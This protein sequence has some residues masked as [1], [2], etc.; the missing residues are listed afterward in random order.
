MSGLCTLI[1]SCP[2]FTLSS[3]RV[4]MSTT[5]PLASE[6]TGTSRAISGFT[7]PV[8]FNRAGASIRLAATNENCSGFSTVTTPVLLVSVTFAGGAAPS[9]GLN[10]FSHAVKERQ[11]VRYPIVCKADLFFIGEPHALRQDS[12]GWR[13]SDRRQ[14]TG[15]RPV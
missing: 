3:R 6:I 10:F 7:D 5:R 15:D 12:F 14:S 4:R 9:A 11:R 8:T 1:R 2:F 13:L